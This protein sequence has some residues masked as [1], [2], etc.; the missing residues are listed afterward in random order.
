MNRVHSSRRGGPSQWVWLIAA[1]GVAGVAAVLVVTLSGGKDDGSPVSDVTATPVPSLGGGPVY[2]VAA[3]EPQASDTNNGFYPTYRGGSDGPWLTLQHAANAMAAGATTYVRSG[4]YYESGIT[5]AAAGLAEAPITL[6][7]YPGEEA[8]VDGSG[9]GGLL[10][11]IGITE[12]QGYYVIQGLTIRHM[13]WSGIATDAASSVPY[14]GIVIRDCVLY[15]NG[16]SGIDL[17]AAVGFLVEGVEAYE[18]GFYGMNVGASEDGSLSSADGV[19]RDSGFYNQL[20]EEGHGLAVNQGHDIV[21]SGNLAHH[22]RIH[23][24]DISDMPKSGELSHDIIVE[25]NSSHDN[26]VG[27]FSINSDSHHVVFRNNTAWSNGT[28]FLCYEG[29]WHIEWYN[30]VAV[31]NSDAGFRVQAALGLYSTPGDSLLVF[32]NNIADGNGLRGSDERPALV[33]EGTQWETI[34]EHNDWSGGAGADALVVGLNIVD[35]SGDIYSAAQINQGAFPPG[36]VS[37]NPQFVDPA[38]ADWHLQATS[39]LIDLGVDVGLPYCGAVPDLGAFE[40][41]P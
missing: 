28:G 1:A 15:A 6:A 39:P 31:G 24:I 13:P 41:C 35:E 27:G 7:T 18:N 37:A 32:K 12:G 5:F 40:S 10:P 11:G 26:G 16:W 4:V 19:V 14:P 9:T 8:I 34:V 25:G 23:G 21:L 17:A 30:N 38:T 36:N 2:Y 3:E 33:V 22:N 20:G 29:C